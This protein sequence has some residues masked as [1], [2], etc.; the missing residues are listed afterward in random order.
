MTETKTQDT[1]MDAAIS[2][3]DGDF[4]WDSPPP[5]VASKKKGKKG[6]PGK[7]SPGVV[8]RTEIKEKVFQLK[9]VNISIPAGQ[10]TAIVGLYPVL[11]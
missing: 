8:A 5:E 6:P 10:L 11:S 2:V 9:G 1:Q 4:T 3:A 7:S